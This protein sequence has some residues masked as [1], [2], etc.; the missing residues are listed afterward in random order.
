MHVYTY[1]CIV[2]RKEKKTILLI[3]K[4]FNFY[5]ISFN[6]KLRS[7]FI[8]CNLCGVCV[9]VYVCIFRTIVKEIELNF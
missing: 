6:K 1:M 2:E 4:N 3:K 5:L 7:N 8:D 9:C